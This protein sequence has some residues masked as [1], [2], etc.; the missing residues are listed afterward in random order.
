MRDRRDYRDQLP[1][2]GV[3]TLIVA[4]QDDALTTPA[5]ARAMSRHIPRAKVAIIPN[6]GHL[7]PMEQPQHVNQAIGSFLAAIR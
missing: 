3:P 6:A 1:S 4:G 7:A 2:I 5:M